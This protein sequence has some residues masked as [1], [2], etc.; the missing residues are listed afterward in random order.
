MP[1]PSN[2][3]RL[4]GIVLVSVLIAALAGCA[5]SPTGR[6]Q[7]LVYP[8]DQLDAMGIQAFE[9]M[10]SQ[11]TVEEDPEINAYVRCVATA[12]TDELSDKNTN[13][14]VV[15]FTDDN[16]NAFAL[17]G[18]KMGVYTGMLKVAE[19]Q[20]Q[21]AA[22]LG[23]EVGHVLA[24]HGNERMS[25]QQI[26]NVALAAAAGSGYVD[27]VSMQALGLGAQIG[28]LLPYSRSHE[29]E[30]DII[31]LDLMAE[32]GFDPRESVQLWK[33]MEKAGGGAP[34]E[35]LSTHPASTTRI[36]DLIGKMA[37]ALHT[38]NDARAKGKKPECK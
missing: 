20:D 22:V 11:L 10:R 2:P 5:T 35:F 23:H 30:A 1:N 36:D 25:Q 18:G 15:V 14:E 31:G 26:T 28:I 21:L 24:Q 6:N 33:N 19:N 27:S 9:E 29:S 12:I 13:W 7:L 34:P 17:P 38:Y 3:R 4:P 16:P 37:D 8:A 32:A